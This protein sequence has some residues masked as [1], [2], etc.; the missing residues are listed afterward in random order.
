VTSRLASPRRQHRVRTV[1]VA[2][3][4]ACAA[5][6]GV[7][8]AAAAAAPAG[9][10]PWKHLNHGWTMATWTAK[11]R[12]GATV[13]LVGPRGRTYAITTVSRRAY[14]LASS[15][16]GTT[17][18]LTGRHGAI[19]LDLRSGH[20]STIKLPEGEILGFAH[21]GH[22]LIEAVYVPHGQYVVP[23]LERFGLNGHHEVS[24]P[25]RTQ[26]AGRLD[27]NGILA[28]AGGRLATGAQHGVVVLRHDGTVLRR[29][30]TNL[31]R[32]MVISKWDRGAALARCGRGALW[33][34]P[35]G[36]GPAARLTD[37]TSKEN[38]FGYELAWRY[39]KGRLGL[40]EN[41]CG[42]SSLVRFN[43]TGH[44]H[45]VTVPSP[46]GHP[47]TPSYVAHHG[48]VVDMIFNPIGGCQGTRDQLFA[49]NAVSH[50]SRTLL[51]GRV[52]GGR[53]LAAMALG[54]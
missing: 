51:G 19:R 12:A 4:A 2:S 17:V 35:F 26:G 25:L 20:R 34:V 5:F 9:H 43:R 32:C 39:S 54:D 27:T 45:R 10:V 8:G 15:A 3:V 52:N 22:S 29:A 36:G 47:G 14:P 1:L 40:A 23:R 11:G 33:A 13:Y 6:L 31:D 46:T 38:P 41:G 42:P 44:G 50:T 18:L 48:N 49:Y 37:G 24:Y 7:T 28:L 16:D 30:A 21:D 53:V